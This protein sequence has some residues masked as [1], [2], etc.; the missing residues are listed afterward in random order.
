MLG[1]V[2]LERIAELKN[3]WKSRITYVNTI[4]LLSVLISLGF[5]IGFI[6]GREIFCW[7]K[8]VLDTEVV[9]HFGDFIG[10]AIGTLVSIVL[11]YHT[12]KLQRRDSEKNTL[13]YENQQLNDLFFHLLKQYDDLLK[14]FSAKNEEEQLQGREALHYN[15]IE[16]YKQFK[17]SGDDKQNQD[18]A[19]SLFLMF[20]SQTRDFSPIYFRSLYRAFK[21]LESS[22]DSLREAS[23]KLMKMLRAQL[24][25]SEL[26]FIRY[27]C[28]TRQG[29]KFVDLVN[30]FNLLKHLPPLELMEYKRW[31]EKMTF[32]ERG[33]TN[34]LLLEAKHNI[35][36]VLETS[37]PAASYSNNP[38]TY[39]I[40]VASNDTATELKVCLYIK[41]DGK[42][43]DSDLIK[44]VYK[45]AEEERLA[46]LCFFVKDCL[47]FSSFNKLNP[48]ARLKIEPIK[49]DED[50]MRVTVTSKDQQPIRMRDT[51]GMIN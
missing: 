7:E 41:H 8:Y 14:T 18:Q 4:C 49:E 35:Q 2:K 51:E 27:N 10:G 40:N 31:A 43:D 25:D 26:V 36:K 16:L 32:D 20:Y 46:F 1:F 47:I 39:N 15:L 45:L 11:L 5:T 9:G 38:K 42:L 22:D 3:K 29:S 21:L 37:L 19:I 24:S 44:G 6:H 48:R 33:Y 12:L 50:K 23:I 28:L 30:K 17:D 13:V 34:V